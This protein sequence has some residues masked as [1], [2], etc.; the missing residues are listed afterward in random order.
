MNVFGKTR[1][2]LIITNILLSLIGLNHDL[3]AQNDCGGLLKHGIY[4][5]FQDNNVSGSAAQMRSELQRVS[6]QM[7]KDEK[8]VGIQASYNLFSG[9][10]SLS[11]SELKILNH[12]LSTAM[13][14]SLEQHAIADKIE[15]I[16]SSDAIKAW[17]ECEKLFNTGLQISSLMPDD[18]LAPISFTIKYIAPDGVPADLN[19][20]P[21]QVTPDGAF[22]CKWTYPK[23][24]TKPANNYYSVKHGNSITLDCSRKRSDNKP[25]EIGNRKLFAEP[26]I[27]SIQTD[28]GSASRLFAGVPVPKQPPTPTDALMTSFPAGIILPWYSNERKPFPIPNGWA[29]C[30]GSN[31]TPDLRD[32]FIKGMPSFN[33]IGKTMGAEN[34]TH[35][36]TIKVKTTG[37]GKTDRLAEHD[38]WNAS[39]MSQKK[40]KEPYTTGFNHIHDISISSSGEGTGTTE[41]ASNIPPS[42]NVLYIIKQ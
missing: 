39:G 35:Q 28:K 31:G 17:S 4:N 27:L 38:G 23:G 13:A 1:S 12:S 22:S 14:S 26:A 6:S 3:I 36:V 42:V 20:F 19:I 34:H 16:I 41:K 40:D 2:F 32:K 30:D 11:S 24:G 5:Y 7:E 8:S 25:I 9:K 15:K 37:N 29:I 10:L 18:Q 21:I 33:E